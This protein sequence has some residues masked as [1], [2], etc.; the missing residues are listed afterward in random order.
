[1]F[2]LILRCSYTLKRKGQPNGDENRFAQ[3]E[4]GLAIAD[5]VSVMAQVLKLRA[6]KQVP[7]LRQ[8]HVAGGAHKTAY[9]Y[10]SLRARSGTVSGG[11]AHTNIFIKGYSF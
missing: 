4:S 9:Q 3:I 11:R 8:C 7:F 5:T 1:M 10:I 6:A 2:Q